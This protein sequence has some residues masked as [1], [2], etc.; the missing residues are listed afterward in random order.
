MWCLQEE[1]CSEIVLE[2]WNDR[3]HTST[4]GLS[5]NFGGCSRELE[6]WSDK[7]FGDIP[8]VL[9][10]C[11]RELA[12]FQVDPQTHET[13]MEAR[14]MESIVSALVRKEVVFWLQRSRASWMREGDRN[15]RFFHKVVSRRRKMNTIEAVTDE[16]GMSHKHEEDIQKVFVSYFSK[17]F[18]T[19]GNLKIEEA[20]EA[21]NH[22]LPEDMMNELTKPFMEE[23][24]TRALFQMHPC[25]APCLDGM[26]VIF[27]K[28]FWNIVM[29]SVTLDVLNHGASP[30][31]LNQ[32]FLALISK[33][34]AHIPLLSLDQL[35]FVM[36]PS[37]LLQNHC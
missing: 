16:F 28:K 35:A 12:R 9:K 17:M 2:A 33:L 4:T 26:S 1:N 6:R 11:T 30:A 8:K 27:L 36:S 37:R 34:N 25:K 20:L 10:K 29:K 3:G 23:E 15:S 5:S 14:S 7:Y 24:V 22:K 32:T 18:T 21:L 13:T 19:K 31:S